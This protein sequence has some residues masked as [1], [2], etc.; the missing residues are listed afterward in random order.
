M[1]MKTIGLLTGL[2]LI[3]FGQTGVFGMSARD[4]IVKVDEVATESS[5]SSIQ[6]SKLSTC[7]YGKKGKKIVCVKK[8]R[9]KV[10]E[11]VQKDSG[12]NG[13]DSKSISIILKPIG[14]SGVGMLSYDYDDPDKDADNWL[15]LSALGKVKRLISG[16]D[17]DTESGSFFFSVIST[18]DLESAKIDE[19][20]YKILK[21]TTYQKRPVWIVESIPTR[22]RLKKSK[23][24]R[25]ISWIDK[26]RFILLKAKMYNKSGKLYKL[27]S[28]RSIQKIDGVWVARTMSVRNVIS[29]RVTNMKQFSIAFNIAV[30]DEF[31]TKRTLT[32]FA[33]RERELRKLRKHLK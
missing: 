26:E 6:K 1:K 22:K 14:E 2:T 11:S 31:L 9:I 24:S 8:P 12:P 5:S 17:D 33:F 32:D 19:Y 27:M 10:M 30:P 23:Y 18:E 20:T 13:K 15:Y 7:K 3:F 16:S 25:S 29:K 28:M 21:E 4:I